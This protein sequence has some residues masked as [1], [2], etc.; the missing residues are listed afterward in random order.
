[1]KYSKENQTLIQ[2]MTASMQQ[3]GDAYG[4]Q[5][6][7]LATFLLFNR[8]ISVHSLGGCILS[9][10]PDKGVVS[11]TGEVFGYK[12]LFIADGSVIPSSIGFHP[13][14]TI[15]AVAEHTAASIC[16]GL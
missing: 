12:N 16:A 15:S 7:P 2:N 8:I 10:N 4:G 1:W 14:M 3:I 6:G 11:E 9:A 5:F 13:V